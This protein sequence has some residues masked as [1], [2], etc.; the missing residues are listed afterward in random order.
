MKDKETNL[1]KIGDSRN[2]N[3]EVKDR[4]NVYWD[5]VIQF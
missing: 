5:L 4:F 2:S 1:K 3:R